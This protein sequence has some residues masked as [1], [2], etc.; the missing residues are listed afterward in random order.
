MTEE[1]SCFWVVNADREVDET[2][3]NPDAT[4]MDESTIDA[5][6]GMINDFIVVLLTMLLDGRGSIN[7]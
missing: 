5:I 2:N 1:E 6:E 3:A 7:K 4:G